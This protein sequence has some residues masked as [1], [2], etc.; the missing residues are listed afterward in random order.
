LF[1]KQFI[2][3][4]LS[5]VL[6]FLL[7]TATALLVARILGPSGRGQL[8][9]LIAAVTA[10]ALVSNMGIGLASTYFLA[11]GKAKLT[12]LIS[13]SLFWTLVCG[14]PTAFIFSF[15]VPRLDAFLS[16]GGY[17]IPVMVA[18]SL[19]P[20]YLLS[21]LLMSILLGLHR[22]V[23]VNIVTVAQ[24]AATL[25]LTMCLM[26]FWQMGLLGAVVATVG[27]TVAGLVIALVI[28]RHSFT[29]ELRPHKALLRD[30]LSFGLRGHAGNIMQF[31]NYR[32]NFFIVNAL[33]DVS[34]VGW[35]SIA[36]TLAESVWYI[37]NAAA[38]ILLPRTASSSPE[39]RRIFTPAVCRH[40][41]FITLAAALL[42]FLLSR[43]IIVTLFTEAYLPSLVPLWLLLPG[44]VALSTSK[45]LT[46]DLA[47]RG[48]PQYGSY[49]A[50]I[51]VIATVSLDLLLIP[52]YG[53]AGAAIASSTSYVLATAFTTYHY[54]RLS[55]NSLSDVLVVKAHDIQQYIQLGRHAISRLEE[56]WYTANS[57]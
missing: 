12:P 1:T 44:V 11:G 18:S 30:S 16:T 47:G 53:I 52:I 25:L 21:G 35:Y 24:A 19:L 39:V 43:L 14:V 3:T 9:L 26:G 45:V 10:L 4:V 17:H 54:V 40:T 42:L 27:G 22:I 29:L 55:E 49:A 33:L 48:A 20:L 5:S 51:G 13:N 31:L 6:S 46:S 23:Q 56:K 38:T 36:V 50:L 28:L 8:S 57:S 7:G 37:P 2:S 34:S 15:F 41:L 32:L